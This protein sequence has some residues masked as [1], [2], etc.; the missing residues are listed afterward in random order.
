MCQHPLLQQ[1]QVHEKRPLILVYWN[2]IVRNVPRARRQRQQ[3]HIQLGQQHAILIRCIIAFDVNGSA[4]MPARDPLRSQ[5]SYPNAERSPEIFSC[6]SHVDNQRSRRRAK[7]EI[8]R[9]RRKG[10]RQPHRCSVA[11]RLEKLVQRSRRIGLADLDLLQPR[12]KIANRIL[13][14]L[15]R[16]LETQLKGEVVTQPRRRHQFVFTA[17]RLT[18]NRHIISRAM[19]ITEH[20][21]QLEIRIRRRRNLR[22]DLLRMIGDPILQISALRRRHTDQL[23]ARAQRN[24]RLNH[25]TRAFDGIDFDPDI[26][27]THG[28]VADQIARE[29]LVAARQVRKLLREV[30]DA[31]HHADIE[32]HMFGRVRVGHR[33]AVCVR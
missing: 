6:I 4:A 23:S 25:H 12:D 1:P 31:E 15:I 13:F 8:S 16:S 2:R 5:L 18:R 27:A 14:A 10:R 24:A 22:R 33:H 11:Y 9:R 30:V 28:S 19:A 17:A 20:D 21:V 29:P 7:H 32:V 3:R 26:Q